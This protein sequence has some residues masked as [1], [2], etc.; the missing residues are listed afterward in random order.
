[1]LIASLRVILQ[2]LYASKIISY[3][4]GF[5]LLRQ[6]ATEFGWTLNYGGIAL[7]WRGG[8]IIRSVFLGR[9]KDAFDRNPELQ[10]LLLD[11][12]FKSAVENCQVRSPEP[13][14]RGLSQRA[15]LW[16]VR[17]PLS[18]SGAGGSLS[19]RMGPVT[20]PV[21]FALGRSPGGGQSARASRRASPCPASPLPF[22]SMTGTD[23][24]CCPPT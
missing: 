17:F 24:R 7:M 8:C 6:A 1:M 21:G 10:N 9:I 19:F 22:P 12:F 11:D 14:A 2:A 4:Q 20:F 23:T 13:L 3:A 18:S 15:S 5:M 16:G